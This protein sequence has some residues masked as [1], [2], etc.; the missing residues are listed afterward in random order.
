VLV[1][2]AGA[3]PE[4]AAGAAAAVLPVS[5]VHFPAAASLAATLKG[6]PPVQQQQQQGVAGLGKPREDLDLNQDEAALLWQAGQCSWHDR[7]YPQLQQQHVDAWAEALQ[8]LLSS[9]S[10]Y[11]KHSRQAKAAAEQVVMKAPELLQQLVGWLQQ[12][13]DA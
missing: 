10:T 11:L 12:M 1:A 13:Y 8:Q 4:A 3:L 9:R 5:L 7:A 6:S 2:D